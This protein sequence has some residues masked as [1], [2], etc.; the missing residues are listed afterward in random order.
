VLAQLDRNCPL[1]RPLQRRAI[2]LLKDSSAEVR[3]ELL[4]ALPQLLPACHTR[5]DGQPAGRESVTLKDSPL[6]GDMLEALV[7]VDS[8]GG[9]SWRTQLCIAKAFPVMATVGGCCCL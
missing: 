8:E 6:A 9:K 5:E 4:P 1:L 2:A 3:R 7:L